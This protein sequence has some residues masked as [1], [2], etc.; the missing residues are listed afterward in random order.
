M[1]S[2]QKSIVA[3]MMPVTLALVV[4][5]AAAFARPVPPVPLSAAPLQFDAGRALTDTVKLT[6]DYPDRVVGAEAGLRARGWII[7]RFLD[8]GLP[9]G[10]LPF[11]VTVASQERAGMQVWAT[12][13]GESDEIILI[14]AHY[15]LSPNQ[16]AGS[17]AGLASLLELARLFAAEPHRH[18]LIFMASDS[19]TY[20]PAWGAKNFAESFGPRDRIVAALNLNYPNSAE[21][22]ILLDSAGLYQGYAPPWLRQAGRTAL[23]VNGFSAGDPDGALEFFYRALPF[24]ATET[25][26]YLRAGIPAIGFS[27]GRS[28]SDPS[29]TAGLQSFGRAAETWLRTAD[30]QA[31]PRSV[32]L[33]YFQIDRTHFL[34]GWIAEPLQLLLF[35]PLF[36]AAAIA[37]QKHRPGWDELQPEFIALMAIVIIG[38]DGY[39]V[40]YSLVNLNLLPR[41]ELYPASPG[42]PFLLHPAWWA[43]LVIGGTMAAF[44]WYTFRGKG[45]GRY[46]DRLDIPY[47]RVTL[48]VFFSAAVFFFWQINAYTVSAL[49]GLAAYLWVWIEPHWTVWGKALNVSLALAGAIPFA[50][51]VY[52]FASQ[53]PV[54]PWWWFLTLGA[55]YGFFPFAAVAAFIFCAA[56]L[57]RF[58]R[59]GLRAA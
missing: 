43:V 20:G 40:A 6:T 5:L 23:E 39:A 16:A 50:V 14:T 51:C 37:W 9:V 19:A 22:Q 35:A 29:G 56:L 17:A 13:P 18:T 53:T 57:L 48:L 28:V 3:L 33:P 52:V 26:A 12:S 34:P 58:L 31:P 47:R 49:L 2:R 25:A 24:A 4:M 36:L 15:D 59:L 8:L 38:L 21:A 30:E 10:A 7:R 27:A 32:A 42:D 46:A 41:Y 45:W 11:T 55:A 44:G 54:G 1:T